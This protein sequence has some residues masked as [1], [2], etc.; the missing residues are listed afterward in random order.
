[1]FFD[2]FFQILSPFIDGAIGCG[3]TEWPES[4]PVLNRLKPSLFLTGTVGASL[5]AIS[6]LF[7]HH[8]IGGEL[9]FGTS[10]VVAP[11]LAALLL[12]L[13][14][15]SADATEPPVGQHFSYCLTLTA[16]VFIA[17]FILLCC[18]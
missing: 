14:T 9:S 16:T 8:P 7:Y 10:I 6:F 13:A 5:G 2:V 11:L 3:V 18:I 12:L 4:I 15:R 1:M 17:R